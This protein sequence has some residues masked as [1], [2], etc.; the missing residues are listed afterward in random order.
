MNEQLVGRLR[1]ASLGVLLQ[2]TAA[3]F[4]WP[5]ETA[6]FRKSAQGFAFCSPD[7]SVVFLRRTLCFVSRIYLVVDLRD[8]GPTTIHA[9]SG[10]CERVSVCVFKDMNDYRK[11]TPSPRS[12]TSLL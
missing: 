6:R 5:P 11:R 1:S 9:A 7:V 3:N 10:V 8:T 4:R 12:R 2:T